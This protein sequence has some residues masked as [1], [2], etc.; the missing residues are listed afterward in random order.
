MKF[1]V[2]QKKIG[3][4]TGMIAISIKFDDPIESR[5]LNSIRRVLLDCHIPTKCLTVDQA[6]VITDDDYFIQNLESA[7]LDQATPQEKVFTLNVSNKSDLPI[8]VYTRDIPGLAPKYQDGLVILTSLMP[9]TELKVSRIKVDTRKECARQSLANSIFA[10]DNESDISELRFNTMG[11]M[12]PIDIIK[13][14]IQ[15]IM[16]KLTS[17]RERIGSIVINE[18]HDSL[19]ES[20][21]I[22]TGEDATIT[23]LINICMQQ[24]YG[25]KVNVTV[26]DFED[27]S[28]SRIKFTVTT[29]LDPKIVLKTAIEQSM[30]FYVEFLGLL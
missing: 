1:K 19:I 3:E 2:D 14:A 8:D 27:K 17:A 12:K 21:I 16:K 7:L 26:F 13:A 6:D 24:L 5:F 18:P 15:V 4:D 30:A 22:L 20:N 25:K 9:R 11:T 28:G 10:G 23:Q 29:D